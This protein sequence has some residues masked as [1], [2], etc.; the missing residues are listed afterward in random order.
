M[1]SRKKLSCI[2]ITFYNIITCSY[3]F[4]FQSTIGKM[5]IGE[6]NFINQYHCAYIFSRRQYNLIY[7]I[8][9]ITTYLFIN[10]FVR[11]NATLVVPQKIVLTKTLLGIKT[12]NNKNTQTYSVLNLQSYYTQPGHKQTMNWLRFF[13]FWKCFG[14]C[15]YKGKMYLFLIS[16]SRAIIGNIEIS[17]HI[18]L[19]Q[20]GKD[21]HYHVHK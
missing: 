2:L 5:W 6:I 17:E 1:I 12:Y 4:K 18:Q 20:T 8:A 3:D 9:L 14:P 21:N 19:V 10:R 7:C 15:I 11:G 16:I 13:L